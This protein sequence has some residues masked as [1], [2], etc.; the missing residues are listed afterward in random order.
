[1]R[2]ITFGCT[3]GYALK[4]PGDTDEFIEF[5]EKKIRQ[6]A[7]LHDSKFMGMYVE[8]E[9]TE[10]KLFERPV[11]QRLWRAFDRQDVLVVYDIMNIR[12]RFLDIATLV[13]ELEKSRRGAHAVFVKDN[14]DTFTVEREGFLQIMFASRAFPKPQEDPQL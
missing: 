12:C 9:P 14:Y 2:P 13:D 3:Y 6:W 7:E 5:Q 8:I 1:M 10:D 11:F 4:S